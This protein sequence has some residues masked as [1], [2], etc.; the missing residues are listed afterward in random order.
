MR[1]YLVQHGTPLTE[2]VDPARPLCDEG[3]AEIRRLT[4]FLG[5]AGVSVERILH[6]GKL[7]AE[8][9]AELL[10]VTLDDG[11]TFGV[12]DYL[13]P[14]SPVEN[15]ALEAGGWEVDAMLVGHLPHLGKLASYLVA[16][17]ESSD[18]VRFRQGGILCLERDDAGKWRVA[19][20]IL[21]ELLN[22]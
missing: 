17:S 18:V 20:M 8:Q 12:R 3:R 6:S 7:R 16:G 2:A 22:A 9:T 19:W 15:L 5:K 14:L 13:S 10:R 1:L 21:P 4:A 11:G